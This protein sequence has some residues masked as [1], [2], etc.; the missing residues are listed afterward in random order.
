MDPNPSFT[1]RLLLQRT[2]STHNI[3]EKKELRMLLG[4]KKKGAARSFDAKR[5]CYRTEKRVRIGGYLY[6]CEIIAI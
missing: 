2:D 1:R 3:I 6:L 5:I 4:S